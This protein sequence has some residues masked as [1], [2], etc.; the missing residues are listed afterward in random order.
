MCRRALAENVALRNA[1]KVSQKYPISNPPETE[2]SNTQ[3]QTAEESH[4]AALEHASSVYSGVMARLEIAPWL[5]YTCTG[6]GLCCRRGFN[7]W[8]PL[9]DRIRLGEVDWGAKYPRL[10]GLQLFI[11]QR[12]NYRLAVAD[13]GQ[14]H[15]LDQDNHC[16][17][18]AELGFHNKVLTCKMF[19]YTLVHSFGRVHVGLLHSCPAVVDQTGQ[20]V[21]A[22]THLL[23]KL[24]EEMDRLFPPPP[25]NEETA[26]DLDRP[27]TFRNLR[28]LEESLIS[29]LHDEQLPLVRRIIYA[30]GLLD[31]LDDSPADQLGPKSF[32]ETLCHH[33]QKA[34]DDAIN[35][36][37]KHRELTLFERVFL[38]QLQGLCSTLAQSGLL[39]SS[40]SK[41]QA[42]RLRRL[43]LAL[44]YMRGTGHLPFSV[45]DWSRIAG[46][47][48]EDSP[49]RTA[50]SFDEVRKV[51]C[52]HLAAESEALISRYLSTRIAG[53][54]YFGKEGWGL[55]VLPGA[56]AIL[57]IAAL[58]MWHAKV[59]AC[60]AGR[61]ATGHEDIRDAVLIV[62]HTFGHMSV[63]NTSFA[64]R[65]LHV[66]NR[67]G[68]PQRALLFTML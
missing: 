57:A 9:P 43:G 62:E 34:R 50:L 45:D 63:L 25:F 48:D 56:R 22:Q 38:R 49:L 47:A 20:P 3:I 18:H 26:F 64:E 42:A 55:A 54:T 6:C 65:A 27:I 15:F 23:G 41:R 52:F 67:T 4:F 24:L 2:I 1:L 5:R 13:N 30:G 16:I 40:F 68:W 66:V 8:C 33:R 7:I 14:C 39:A 59:R 61:N 17:M 51:E 32:H 29:A 60:A 35:C 53:R 12:E 37:L 19:P 44:R 31:R 10:Q 46:P 11:P 36:G 28:F 58:V 21:T